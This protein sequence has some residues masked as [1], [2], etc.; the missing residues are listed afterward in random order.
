[1]QEELRTEPKLKSK[2]ES[3]LTVL[4]LG[5]SVI[6]KK[7]EPMTP[8]LKVMQ[9]LAKEIADASVEHMIIVHGGGSFGH[10]LAKQYKIKEGY[11]DPTQIEGFLKTH[12]AMLELN[13]L[14]VDALIRH[15][16]PAFSISPSSC[17]VTKGSR[18]QIFY[19]STLTRLLNTGFV[20]VLFGDAVLDNNTG[21]NILSGDQLIATLAIRF[22]A[23]KIILGVDVDGLYT[24]DPKTNARANLMPH[25]TLPNLKTLMHNIEEAKVTDVTG[26]MLGKI[27]ELIPAI[28]ADIKTF[29]VNASKE[30]NVYKALKGEKVAGTLIEK[31]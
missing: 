22:K 26:G 28:N 13:K 14:V 11:K 21:F 9:R 15:N 17:V 12:Q 1:L 20:P 8:N 25:I 31:E 29:I 4:K 2:T 16:I 23:D 5:G 10:P 27:S 3:Q 7:D 6:T 24:A 30:A 19:D 18:I